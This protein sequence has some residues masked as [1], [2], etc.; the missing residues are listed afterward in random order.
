MSGLLECTGYQKTKHV[1]CLLIIS[2]LCLF[3]RHA[4]DHFKSLAARGDTA[5][6]SLEP[7]ESGLMNPSIRLIPWDVQ[8]AT[9]KG[10]PAASQDP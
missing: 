3:D 6:L 10:V 1:D 8:P 2:C 4:V 9:A 5:Q 7:D